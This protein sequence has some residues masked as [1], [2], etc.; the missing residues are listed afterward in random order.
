MPWQWTADRTTWQRDSLRTKQMDL[1]A[2]QSKAEDLETRID[3]YQSEISKLKASKNKYKQR[4]V[5]NENI[6][7]EKIKLEGQLEKLRMQKAAGEATVARTEKAIRE[8]H[9]KAVAA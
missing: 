8:A 7:V 6:R 5:D 2:A 9:T 1:S 4:V 3:V